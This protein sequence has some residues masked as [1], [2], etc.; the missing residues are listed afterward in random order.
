MVT[1]RGLWFGVLI[2]AGATQGCYDAKEYPIRA[3]TTLDLSDSGE[4]DSSELMIH[5]HW[6]AYADAYDSPSRCT[7]K[8]MHQPSESADFSKPDPPPRPDPGAQADS[9]LVAHNRGFPSNGIGMCTTGD[10]EKVICAP[11]VMCSMDGPFDF[12]DMWGGGIGVDFNLSSD[13]RGPWNPE[14]YGVVGVAFDLKPLSDDVADG[15]LPF[16]SLRVEFPIQFVNSVVTP[17]DTVQL[18]G[19]PVAK[20]DPLPPPST[21][22]EYP[23][24]SY[25][26]R[27]SAAKADW[28]SPIASGHNEVL[29]KDLLRP[30]TEDTQ[31][32]IYAFDVTNLLGVQF[33]AAPDKVLKRHYGF[34]INNLVLIHK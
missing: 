29:F 14:T 31:S 4:V 26:W 20:G 34:C 13:A 30:A 3:T 18:N 10:V 33:H 19:N 11:D 15:D 24:G 5:G 23:G 28:D 16:T 17:E 27:A 22:E 32:A 2:A 7:V 6:Y 12:S 21:S 9:V 1:R 25:L 8:G